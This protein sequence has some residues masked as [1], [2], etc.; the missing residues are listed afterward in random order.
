[1]KHDIASPL[2]GA[3]SMLSDTQYVTMLEFEAYSYESETRI[4]LSRSKYND[5]LFKTNNK[6]QIVPYINIAIDLKRLKKIVIGPCCCEYD[7]TKM[8]IGARLKQLN[9]KDVKILRSQIP[10]R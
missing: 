2:S 5:V 10:Y 3:L 4:L 8:M 7:T 6:G 1:M 9:H